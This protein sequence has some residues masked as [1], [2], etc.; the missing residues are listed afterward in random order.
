M[1]EAKHQTT[2]LRK[3]RYFN[4]RAESNS[5]YVNDS[6][7]YRSL[8]CVTL[9]S[10]QYETRYFIFNGTTRPKPA[11]ANQSPLES[12]KAHPEVFEKNGLLWHSILQR[13]RGSPM[14]LLLTPI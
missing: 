3:A 13:I 9:L 5:L 8:I 11:K 4:N 12:N 6:D 14:N 7:T 10:G 2:R 1:Q